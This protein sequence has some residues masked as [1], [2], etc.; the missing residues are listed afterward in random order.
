MKG[1]FALLFESAGRAIKNLCS[2]AAS[3]M[4]RR[5]HVISG[6]QKLLNNATK[7]TKRLLLLMPFWNQ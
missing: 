4:I 3:H 6:A 5:A 1:F 7:P 2:G